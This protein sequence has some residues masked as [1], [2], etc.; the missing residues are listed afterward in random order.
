[1]NSEQSNEPKVLAEIDSLLNNGDTLNAVK[2]LQEATEAGVAIAPHHINFAHKL[3][4][5][6]HW[7][8]IT[9]LLPNGTNFFVSSGW[10]KSIVKSRPV[11]SQEKPVPWFTYPAIDFLDGIIQADWNVLEYGSGNS[12]LWWASRVRN[13][14]AI[15]NNKTWYEEI[16][17]QLP[18]N[19][20]IHLFEEKEDYISGV[21]S[22]DDKYDVIVIDG[23][24]RNEC[25]NAGLPHLENNGIIVFDNADVI[26]HKAAQ[27]RLK[28]EGFFRIDFWGLIPSYLYKNCTSIYFK[29]SS[30]LK[31]RFLP[32]QHVSS[33]G[34][35]CSQALE[36][37]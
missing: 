34:L 25:A 12:T 26:A 20:S 8:S 32:H 24:H 14:V 9:Q 15:E 35:S 16:R 3:I 13:I 36:Q 2:K 7:K 33:V 19:A 18:E 27:E 28:K 4:L 11:N 10:L 31:P 1:M 6:A 30:I 37:R 17:E 21:S 22:L 29:D 5:S 23:S